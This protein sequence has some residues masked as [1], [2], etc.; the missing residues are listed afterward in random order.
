MSKIAILTN[1]ME[2][3]PGYSLTGI[4][5]DQARMLSK[6]GNEVL[7]FVNEKY[8]GGDIEGATIVP[9]IPFAH[10][11]DYSSKNQLTEDHKK[12]VADTTAMLEEN[13]KDVPFVLTHDFMF[14]GWFMPYGLA[15]AKASASL[16]DTAWFHWVH[17]I[18][19][20][21][22]DWW[23]IREFGP[24]HKIV[25]PNSTDALLVAEQYQ[26]VLDD[27]RVIPHIKDVRSF[28]E[29]GEDTCDFIDTYPGVMQADVVQ[30]YPASVDRLEPKRVLEVMKVLAE[31]K[32]LGLSVFLLVAAQWATGEKQ[33]QEI[34]RFKSMAESVGLVNGDELVFSSDWN[35]GKYKIGLPRKM[36]RELMMLSNLF[37]FPTREESFGLVLP[38][39]ALSSGAL[40]VLNRSLTMQLEISDFNALYF[41]FG[42]YYTPAPERNDG[43]YSDLAIV[44]T[45]RM[46]Q[47][48]S[49][50][51]KTYM[52][53]HYNWDY[54]Y[55][56]HYAPILGESLLETERGVIE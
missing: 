47:S 16:P 10:L 50:M 11:K 55:A 45:G 48:E 51:T 32:S 18:P 54:L 53:Q 44:I 35:D 46:K 3:Q 23:R 36:L 9:K 40:C 39:V 30:V 15:C 8:S 12:T 28:W 4:V 5:Q 17:S 19:S 33:L 26:G 21:R 13:L 37:I 31:M 14:T 25:Y 6:Y 2:F 56:R 27:V 22:R 42:S 7:L 41:E 52:R 1:F 29:F 24:K 43:F 20:T 38:E 49:L 34:A